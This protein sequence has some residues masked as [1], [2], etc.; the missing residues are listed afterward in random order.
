MRR[1]KK[2]FYFAV[3]END[4]KYKKEITY[5]V[6]AKY[7]YKG[8][9]DN[10][11]S[12]RRFIRLEFKNQENWFYIRL[13]Q[14]DFLIDSSVSSSEPHIVAVRLPFTIDLTNKVFYKLF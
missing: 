5:P 1:I 4:K 8:I 3:T 13:P 7:R 12:L 9:H 2:Y 6:T 11:D 10:L 14:S